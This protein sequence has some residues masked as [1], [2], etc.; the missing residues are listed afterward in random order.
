MKSYLSLVPISAK[1]HKRQSRM[2][3]I[4]IVLAVFLV[5]SIISMAEM[6]TQSEL[7]AMRRNHGDW[8]I[9]LQ[10]LPENEIEEIISSSDVAYSSW[11]SEINENADQGYYVGGKN[12]V[13]Y[14]VEE[15]YLTD[16]V[17]YPAEGS[18]PQT[19]SEVA[20]SAE[21]KEL[22]GINIG[23]QVVINTPAGDFEY[24]VSGF[25][26]DDM[27]F[28]NIIQG[29]CA[30]INRTAFD[31]I[32]SK[33]EVDTV[34]QFYIRFQK[35]S[36]LKK[37]I[38]D[39]KEQYH[40]T[41]E[42]IRENTGVLG[43]LGASSS[44]TFNGLYPLAA[45]CMVIILAAGVLMISG[46]MNSNVAQRTS[47]FGMLRCIGASKQQIVN[48]VR[49]EALNWCKS[50]I[51]IG[52]ALG[53]AICWICC[54]ILRF[55]VK[56]EWA[57]MPLFAVSP[58]G[59]LCG[60]VV[61]IITVLIAAHSPAKQAAKVSPAAAVTG[62]TD[63]AKKIVHAANTKLF[64]VETSLGI[65]H[66]TRRKKNL[67]LMTG[68]FALTII[69]FLTFS[70][71]LDVVNKLLPSAV[72]EFTPDI[73]IASENDTNSIDRDLLNAIEQVEGVDWAFGFGLYAAYPVEVN[74]NDTTIDLFSHD[75]QLLDKF[76]N[77]VVSGDIEKVY[78][79]E[80]Y[81]MAVY[82]QSNRL[83]V[84]DKIKIGDQEVE[85]ACVT[86]EGIGSVSDAP[87]VV[88]SEETFARLTGDNGF[89]TLGV[90]LQKDAPEAA[91]REI[92][93]LA[94]GNLVSDNRE[95]NSETSGS[96]WV[97][98]IAAYGFL[99]IISLITVLNIM[100]SISMSV[101]A[102]IKQYGVMRAVGMGNQQVTK[103]ITAEATT[104]AACGTVTGIAFGLL[105][106][107][108]IYV[109]IIITHFGGGW[110]IPFSTIGIIILLVMFSC[111]VAV[112]GPAKRMQ[113]MAITETINEL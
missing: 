44:E 55:F 82:N 41:D 26:E 88:C 14:G 40:L 51:P 38:A 54:A 60:A 39:L 86:S 13:I 52:C 92:Y 71:C 113:S 91:V 32:S 42:N 65:N 30:Y 81:A 27:E 101:S 23:D 96:Y 105:F 61:G 97:F 28:N 85:I 5:T 63:E 78:G 90:V 56:G 84:G 33:N 62:N 16:M 103:M 112:H 25:Y 8:H 99:A 98:R 73:T 59:I 83:S 68:S 70:A 106:H 6:W 66:A 108:L 94:E 67:F 72:S 79:D 19:E 45:A 18:Y 69:L 104:Y 109:K 80:N 35:E 111:I 49:L 47:F 37:L 10:N 77:S 22:F 21:A 95:S 43:L 57:D 11:Y 4:C 100:N 9:A 36:G 102:R 64:K 34:S 15:T 46:C 58:A 24:T 75:E 2:T 107:Y 93:D 20:L 89:V 76:K 1:V 87:T 50:A 17:N 3:W 29:C 53:T 31:E 74:G 48:Y 7:T 110:N 12:V